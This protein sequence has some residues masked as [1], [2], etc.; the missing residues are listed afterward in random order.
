MTSTEQRLLEA[1][2]H[3]ERVI[4]VQQEHIVA[5]EQDMR[6]VKYRRNL[7]DMHIPTGSSLN[8]IPQVTP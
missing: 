4:A 1:L 7:L 6:L 8:L 5:M 2:D 3:A